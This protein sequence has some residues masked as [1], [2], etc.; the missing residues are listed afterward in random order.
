TD[1]G[2]AERLVDQHGESIRYCRDTSNWL[3]WNGCCWAADAGAVVQLAKK[4]VRA[5]ELEH[6]SILQC[7][8]GQSGGWH[9]VRQRADAMWRWAQRSESAARIDAMLR[10]AQSDPRVTIQSS[11]LDRD[12][13][14][15]N[16]PNGTLDLRSYKLRE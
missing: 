6:A 16:L 2:N 3:A 14:V 1:C 15:L 10:L 11:A 8:T 7:A 5:M 9:D 12:E 13:W 4:T